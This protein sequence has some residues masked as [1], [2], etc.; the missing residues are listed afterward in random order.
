MGKKTTD[1]FIEYR[2]VRV[3]GGRSNQ[4]PVVTFRFE[5]NQTGNA[6][7]I[8]WANCSRKDQFSREKGRALADKRA[9]EGHVVAGQY[10]RQ[11]D[12]VHNA[13]LQIEN[14]QATIDATNKLYSST[15]I[16]KRELEKLLENLDEIELGSFVE[17]LGP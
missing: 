15:G 8:S 10:F 17:E 1:G 11:Y 4:Y 6:I 9:K 16:T 3:K 14:A 5:V 2:H 13:V 12:L 7:D